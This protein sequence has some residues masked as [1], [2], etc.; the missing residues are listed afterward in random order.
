MSLPTRQILAIVT[1][2]LDITTMPVARLCSFSS[3]IYLDL[4]RF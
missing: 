1:F 4:T 3:D 2:T